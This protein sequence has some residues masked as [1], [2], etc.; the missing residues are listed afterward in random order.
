MLKLR[1]G[2]RAGRLTCCKLLKAKPEQMM[3]PLGL[4]CVTADMLGG[5]ETLNPF[6]AALNPKP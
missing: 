5:P 4:G 2:S 3:L 1:E 6:A